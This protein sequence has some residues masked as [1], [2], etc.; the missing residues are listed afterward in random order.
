MVELSHWARWVAQDVREGKLAIKY[1]YD[2]F[3]RE[4][5]K[6]P[7]T[8][9]FS[10]LAKDAMATRLERAQNVAETADDIQVLDSPIQVDAGTASGIKKEAD[11]KLS[12]KKPS[13][14]CHSPPK[15]RSSKLFCCATAIQEGAIDYRKWSVAALQKQ[16]VEYGLTKT[17]TKAM[18]IERLNAPHPPKVWLERKQRKKFV[19]TRH[20]S[21]ATAI[22]VGLYLHER[23]HGNDDAY[24]GMTKEEL[25]TQAETLDISKE[26]FSGGNRTGPYDYDGWSSMAKLIQGEDP[27]LVT[28]KKGRFKL[29]RSCSIAGYPLAEALHEWC[30]QHNSC[31]CGDL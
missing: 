14:G 15:E 9:D 13:N 11:Q 5:Q 26:P 27:A 12:S 18:L 22:L 3:E 21:C 16:C 25:Y 31:K 23:D 6:L 29:T 24:V 28:K 4:V 7:K 2:E 30:H 19:P 10:R 17:G 20:D 1:T 8:T